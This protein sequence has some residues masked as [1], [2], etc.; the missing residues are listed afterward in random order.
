MANTDNT[1][2][3]IYYGKKFYKVEKK[4]WQQFALDDGD[5]GPA[6]AL[7][8]AGGDIGIPPGAGAAPGEGGYSVVLNLG[9]LI[10]TA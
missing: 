2:I 8:N 4:T 5:A 9:A 6:K 10:K 1:D 7:I 3:V